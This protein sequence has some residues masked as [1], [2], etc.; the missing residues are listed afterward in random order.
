MKTISFFSY[1]GGAGRSSILYNTISFLAKELNATSEHPIVVMD[2]DIDSKGLSYLLLSDESYNPSK[3]DAIKILKNPSAY[4]NPLDSPK[5]LYSKMYAV[6]DKFGL[7]KIDSV[8]FVSA[9]SN[10]TLGQGSNYDGENISLNPFVSALKAAGC[11][12]LVM[13]NP[14]GGQ[15]SSDVA[16]RISHKIV[17]ALRI[18]GQFRFG[19]E[20]FLAKKKCFDNKEYIVVPNAVPSAEGTD[21]NITDILSL[22]KKRFTFAAQK[23]NDT[24]NTAM[25]D[26]GGIGE[27]R[28]FKFEEANLVL[29]QKLNRK[30]EQDEEDAMKK[31]EL[32]AKELVK[33]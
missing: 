2:L 29:K 11:S 28:M 23:N 19:T 17:L 32:L 10:E 18:T 7:D 8:L 25:L 20:E 16:L 5:T 6:G 14:A 22:I 15:L 3:L 21:Y 31:Y 30:I 12:A 26:Q 1:K 9:H 13:D 24:I 33:E 4:L 27:V